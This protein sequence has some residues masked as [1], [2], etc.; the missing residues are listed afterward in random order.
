MNEHEVNYPSDVTIAITAASYSG[1]KGAAAMLQS[2]IKQLYDV[3]GAGLNI[4]LMSVYPRNDALQ[5]PFDFVNIVPAPPDR[6]LFAA[7]PLALLYFLFRWFAPVRKLLEKNKIIKAYSQTDAVIDEAGISFVDSRGFVMNTYAFVSILIPMLCGVPVVKYSQ[8]MG[9]FNTFFNR[10]YGKMI[11][12]KVKLIC[13][14]GEITK[15]NLADIGVTDN[16]ELCADGAFS[17]PDDDVIK[18]ETDMMRSADADFYNDNV[19]ALSVSSVVEKKCGKAGID[20]KGI[21]A[22][23][24]DYLAESGYH[25]L[26]IANAAREGSDKPRNN[27]LIV[28]TAIF[29]MI[30]N[31]EA[32]RWYR[33]EMTA[34]KIR[35]L[36]A[37]SRIL[38]ASRFHAMIGAL[39]KG[40]PV[41]LV[42]WS[43]KYKEVL[44][45]FGL[46]DCAVDFTQLSLEKLKSDFDAFA[47][48]EDEVR[49]QIREAFPA[50]YESS[51]RNIRLIS[52]KINE[53][54]ARRPRKGLLDYNNTAKYLG[55]TLECRTGYAADEEIRKNAASGG[56]VTALLCGM[57]E[58]KE[59]DGAWVTRSVV[60]DGSLDYE[61][62]VATSPEEIRSCSSS[63]YMS[64]PMLKH[65]DVIR[66]FS[67]KVAVVML[68]CQLRMLNAILEKDPELKEKVVCRIGL[69][70]SCN[71]SKE[72]TLLAIRKSGFTLDNAEKFYFRR[73][74]WRGYSSIINRDGT[75]N[76]FSYTKTLCAYKN[77]YFHAMPMCMVCQDQF[78]RESDIS[79]GDI[80]L[81]EMKA[82]KIKHSEVIIRTEAGKCHFDAA[83][84]AGDLVSRPITRKKAVRSQKRALAF[85]YNCAKAK[86]KAYLKKGK[87]ISLDTSDRCK[88][89]HRLAYRLAEK[90][91]AFSENH[92][93]RLEKVP[94]KLV[95]LYMLAIRALLSF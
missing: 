61:T 15:K 72:D 94:M 54:V 10:L 85:K 81:K 66:S 21:M 20:Y 22:G 92:P 37:G 42:G 70:C 18:A 45:M 65:I 5:V 80:W 84:K 91:R 9:P 13:A 76:S 75:E 28:G 56:M 16:V 90:N 68:P 1:N 77:A 78:A 26:I 73:G 57:L 2:S 53:E 89:N 83:V 95:Y 93:E 4:N 47:E 88:W 39:Y 14:R 44:D 58:R 35:E 67:G 23:F 48:K 32:V 25:V 40:T 59:I 27:D 19:V 34:E 38:V 41:L 8:A 12:P 29:D 62:F 50:V 6:L 24:A 36:I 46:G 69:F 82:E 33:E 43:H 17:M 31:K 87:R 52:E 30:E 11:L 3:Y 63:V 71:H 49:E 60:K 55:S 51:L 86:E 79:F 7:F 74:L 64:V